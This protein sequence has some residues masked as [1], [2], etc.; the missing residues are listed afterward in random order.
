MTHSELVK[1]SEYWLQ[2]Q[3][4]KYRCSFTLREYSCYSWEQPDVIGWQCSTLLSVLIECKATRSDFLSD[5][6]KKFRANPGLGAGNYRFY[7][8]PP[9]LIGIKDLPEYWGL[10]WIHPRKVTLEWAPSSFD[11]SAIYR[12]EMPFLVSALRRVH[13]R[14]DLEK[15]YDV[16]TYKRRR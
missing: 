2:Q 16:E 4:G 8:C 5:R 14:G 3:H 11:N 12:N 15:I 6:K 1:R 10:L 7:A 9:K 13:L